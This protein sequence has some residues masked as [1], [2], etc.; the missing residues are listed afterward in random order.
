ME[1]KTRTAKSIV[2][3]QWMYFAFIGLAAAY[4]VYRWNDIPD[5]FPIHWRVRNEPNVWAQRTPLEVFL[6]LLV[7]V[8]VGLIFFA[9]SLTKVVGTPLK[10]SLLA[11]AY[12]IGGAL[13]FSAVWFPFRVAT[14]MPVGFIVTL[15]VGVVVMNFV[16]LAVLG[17]SSLQ[18]NL[19]PAEPPRDRK[20][21]YSKWG[22][23]RNP[24]DPDL[25]VPKLYGYGWTINMAHPKG[26]LLAWA[27]FAGIAVA[28]LAA[29]VVVS[30]FK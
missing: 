12:L 23:Y 13:A 11:L 5:R 26:R 9:I 3:L 22:I 6:P 14:T 17:L 7:A 27:T 18:V 2:L 1:S 29:I 4:L 8:V 24:S 15:L 20:S 10:A 19:L 25:W 30:L 16:F 21:C 28:F